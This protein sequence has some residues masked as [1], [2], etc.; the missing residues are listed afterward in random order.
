MD[1]AG[2]AVD[3]GAGIAAGLA[4][5]F[6]DDLQFSP[7]LAAVFAAAQYE[8][9]LVVVSAGVFA[10]FTKGEHGAGREVD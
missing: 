6:D 5:G 7:G 1:P 10:G 9:D 2:V 3:D 4:A 8:V